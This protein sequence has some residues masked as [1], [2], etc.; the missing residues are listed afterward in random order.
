M[1]SPSLAMQKQIDRREKLSCDEFKREYLLPFK[2]VVI[3][4]GL[5]SWRALSTWTPNYFKTKFGAKIVKIDGQEY[6]MA[7]FIDMVLFSTDFKPAPYLRNEIINWF[8]PELAADIDPLPDYFAPN[9]LDG[10]LSKMLHSRLHRGS[11][12]LYIGGRG[13]KF[14]VLHFD[15]SHTHAF[16]CQIYGVKEFTVYQPD[17]APYLYISPNR[18]NL[19]EIRDTD[20]PDLNKF[21]LFANAKSVR[22]TLEP[23]QILF[24]PGG[25]WHT[26]RML[27][28]SISVSVNRANASNWT[29][30]TRDLC[31]N[32]PLPMKP[33]VALY[34][35]GLRVFR[36]I[37]G[38]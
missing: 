15:A 7:E 30:L 35:S 36:T 4:G 29:S 18:Y 34:L 25:V 3:T 1:A 10:P 38:S 23:G 28:P 17:Q 2:P 5:D 33:A 37:Y 12:E 21:P 27:T 31:A 14:P 16:I 8:L 6:K 32:A 20:N 19:S 22:F 26:A 11:P 24:I 13:G 9:W